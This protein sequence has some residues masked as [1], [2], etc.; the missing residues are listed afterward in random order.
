MGCGFEGSCADRMPWRIDCCSNPKAVDWKQ[1]K[2][3]VRRLFRTTYIGRQL[4]QRVDHQTNSLSKRAKGTARRYLH[5][6]PQNVGHRQLAQ[7]NEPEPTKEIY[8]AE[9]ED[10]WAAQGLAPLISTLETEENE[11]RTSN[12][13]ARVGGIVEP[14]RIRYMILS[15]FEL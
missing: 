7:I 10:D 1:S 12:V 8:L 6:R 15:I 3:V 2:N 11:S 9:L 13:R 14:L 4:N 5:N